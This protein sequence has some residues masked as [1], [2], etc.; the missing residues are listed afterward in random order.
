MFEDVDVF[1][2]PNCKFEDSSYIP[3]CRQDR[4]YVKCTNCEE[5]V[6]IV[7]VKMPYGPYMTMDQY[8]ELLKYIDENHSFAK[9]DGKLIKYATSKFDFR[10][11][12]IYY[13]KLNDKEFYKVNENRHKDLYKWI[14][15]YLEGD[16]SC[17]E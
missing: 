7:I 10:T 9:M 8:L 6:K 15:E 11:K 1:V 17:Q 16:A 5:T 14:M 12:D 2:C 13:V 4:E 3:I